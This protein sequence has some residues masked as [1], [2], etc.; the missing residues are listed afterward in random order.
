VCN[1]AEALVLPA[2]ALDVP[3]RSGRLADDRRVS[4]R[5]ATAADLAGIVD[6][7]ERLS[8]ASR[9]LRFFSPQPRMRRAM[10]DQVV[11]PGSDRVTIMAQPVEFRATARHVVAVGGWVYVSH[12]DRCE[13]SIAVTDTWQNAM[14]GTY[15]ALVLLQAAVT[16]GHARLAAEVL[17]SNARM[18]GLLRDLGAAMQTT[19][20]G[21]VVRLEFEL[22]LAPP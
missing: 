21:G 7:F 12:Q 11:A 15:M 17:S 14:L 8:A 1:G 2:E 13:I 20:E 6:F 10:V 16:R 3:E 5:S 18:L 22:P 4:I 9:Y 19:H